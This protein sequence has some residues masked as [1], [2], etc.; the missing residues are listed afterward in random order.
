MRLDPANPARRSAAG[1]L[2]ALLAL[3]AVGFGARLTPWRTVFTPDGVELLPADSH[4]YVRFAK[5][6][7]DS[8]PRFTQVDPWVNFPSRPRIIWP[9][10]HTGL[11]AATV[12][13]AGRDRAEAGAA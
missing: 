1:V 5:L 10:L 11:V 6:Q 9:P 2:V 13:L 12:A 3:A 4:Y 8:F 7:L